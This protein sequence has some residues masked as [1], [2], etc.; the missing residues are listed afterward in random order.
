MADV[1]YLNWQHFV[2]PIQIMGPMRWRYWHNRKAMT[3]ISDSCSGQCRLIGLYPAIVYLLV[4]SPIFKYDSMLLQIHKPHARYIYLNI[5][6]SEVDG[7]SII[8]A[9]ARPWKTYTEPSNH[10]D[11]TNHNHNNSPVSGLIVW[12]C[13]KIQYQ[14]IQPFL[15]L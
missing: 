12:S 13:W 2:G 7:F 15:Q 6:V 5:P 9:V 1:K 10:L 11:Q 8:C 3:R 14:P 4:H